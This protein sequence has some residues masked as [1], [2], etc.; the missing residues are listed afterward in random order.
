MYLNRLVADLR[1]VGQLGCTEALVHQPNLTSFIY[2]NYAKYF[3]QPII[4]IL[5]EW[6]NA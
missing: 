1:D 2:C 3:Q 4:G 5:A 6:S